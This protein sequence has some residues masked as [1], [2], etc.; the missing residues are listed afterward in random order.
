M[1]DHFFHH[2]NQI[3]CAD[4][5]DGIDNSGNLFYKQLFKIKIK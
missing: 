5:A 1:M 2:F 3:R 4:G